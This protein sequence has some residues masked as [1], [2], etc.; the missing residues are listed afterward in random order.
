M[1]IF[2]NLYYYLLK[3]R[4]LILRNFITDITALF[5]LYL[6]PYC[7]HKLEL[8]DLGKDGTAFECHNENCLVF[9]KEFIGKGVSK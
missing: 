1:D 8:K 5:G 9:N 7:G 3:L 4:F 6:C 2:D